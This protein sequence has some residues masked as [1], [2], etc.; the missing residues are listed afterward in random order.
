M[1]SE[2]VGIVTLCLPFP[3]LFLRTESDTLRTLTKDA[4]EI[5]NILPIYYTTKVNFDL[6]KSNHGEQVVVD[7][8]EEGW[9]CLLYLRLGRRVA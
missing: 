8:I 6:L 5:Y 4:A 2:A 9:G 3:T 7:T 1:G